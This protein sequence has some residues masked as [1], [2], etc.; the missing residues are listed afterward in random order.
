M[1]VLVDLVLRLFLC[2]REQAEDLP[3]VSGGA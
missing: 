1:E 2:K 3:G